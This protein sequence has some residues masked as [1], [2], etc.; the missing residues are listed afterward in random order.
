MRIR[1]YN[2]SRS[3]HKMTNLS[4]GQKKALFSLE[5]RITSEST[6]K[7]LPYLFDRVANE[8]ANKVFKDKSKIQDITNHIEALKALKSVFDL[9]VKDLSH[10]YLMEY[11][12]VLKELRSA[13]EAGDL[14]LIDDLEDEKFILDGDLKLTQKRLSKVEN[15]YKIRLNNLVKDRVKLERLL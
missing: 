2:M 5:N 7:N 9:V 6:Y 8:L 15:A 1:T 11:R 10:E 13:K 3:V 14:D 4:I 12:N